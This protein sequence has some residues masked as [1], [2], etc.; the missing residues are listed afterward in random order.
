MIKFYDRHIVEGKGFLIFSVLFAVLV[1]FVYFFHLDASTIPVDEGGVLWMPLV[2]FFSN[3][4]YS[5]VASA[6]MLIVIASVVNYVN[7]QHVFIRKRTL[8]PS[9]IVIL[10]FSCMPSDL[11]MS[12]YYV[13]ALSMVAI[14]GALFESH[15][16]SY[17][18]LSA[19]KIT[20]FLILGSLFIPILL[21]YLP[22]VW[23]CMARIRGLS[24]KAFL[25]SVFSVA[26]V[27][28]PIYSYF[29]FTNNLDAFYRPFLAITNVD[30]ASLPVLGYNTI[31]FVLLGTL[32]I[33]YVLIL[34]NNSVN[35]FKDKIRVRIFSATVT[36]IVLFSLVFT[37]LLNID[38]ATTL[39][40][41]LAA[42]SLQVGHFFSL[43]EKKATKILFFCYL[44][45]F[46]GFSLFLFL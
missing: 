9:A 38:S 33:L 7:A 41:G 25:A 42:G 1:R 11:A 5:L 32:L 2:D 31:Q 39:F 18:Q 23:I 29:L 28:I 35:S 17:M 36:I 30:W 14:I 16:A 4:L 8:L 19:C 45:S 12:P 20:F 46:I 10:S 13:G 21:L 15:S 34:L 40:I 26:I 24:I 44:F 43:A 37:L 27:Y 3:P 22:V 6:L